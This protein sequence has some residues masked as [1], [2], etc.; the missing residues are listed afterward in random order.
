[1]AKNDFTQK[2]KVDPDE[3]VL[4]EVME[5]FKN[6]RD[7]YKKGYKDKWSNARKLY[8][9]QRV[10]VNYE[11][12]SDTFV[13][14]T[15]TIIQAV[16]SNVIGGK[17][18][19]DFLPTTDE[20]NGDT[21][22]LNA[23]NDQWWTQ[24]KTKLKASWAI[25][26]SLQVGN[27]YLWQYWNGEYP[28]NQYIPT[29]DNF[30]DPAATNYENLQWGGYRYLTTKKELEDEEIVN[31]QYNP[32]DDKSEL[33][34]KRY[35]NLDKVDE[36]TK[37]TYRGDKTAK[38]LREEMFSGST[39]NED[40]NLVE[41]IVFHDK[42]KIVRIANRC[43]VIENGDTWA[44]REASVI[45]SVDD[46]GQSVPVEIPEIE[47]FI[48]VAPARDYVDGALWYARGE[49][50][51][52]GDLQELLNDTQNQKSDNMALTNNMMAILDPSEAEKA[53]EIQ[54]APG[55]IFTL[56][57]GSI[58]FVKPNGIG[59]DADN[60]MARIQSM[61]GRATA[62]NELVQGASAQ[63]TQ[64]A[65]EINSR[66]MQTGTRFAS[67][68]E[69]YE[70]EFFATLANNM[71]KIGQI[72]MTQE[73]AVRMIGSEGVEWKSYNPGE[74][75]GNWD[76]KV[77]L[78]ANAKAIKEERKQE[79]MQFFLMA[80]KIPGVNVPQLARLTSGMLFDIDQ[81]ILDKVFPNEQMQAVQQLQMQKMAAETQQAQL[82]ALPQNNMP[83]GVAPQDAMPQQ[84][85][86]EMASAPQAQAENI[87][88]AA[89]QQGN[90]M[91]TPGMV[92][93]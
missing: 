61:M 53:D 83:Q 58:E 46:Q 22:V 75:L 13:P 73:Q 67:K 27:G 3:Q 51:V 12:S 18:K 15:F 91:N 88:S 17:V 24:D 49:I 33:M 64:S 23:L 40:K 76:V 63:G 87:A 56:P 38:Q 48:P 32:E 1:M 29:E 20:Q 81:N 16:K 43:T 57:P 59:Q 47:A 2:E 11:G 31:D 55:A 19:L 28:C 69:N 30:F 5:K 44:K 85:Q 89:V 37:K 35:K 25:E 36:Y 71:F 70:S 79:A 21:K 60:E 8:N 93:G 42:E 72:F 34:T 4:A 90:G 78:E 7:Y 86:G 6:A 74:Y 54:I 92:N 82:Q 66:L 68:L 45:Q 80:S 9:S 41:I 14:E 26:D 52:I 10:A 65:T 77:S 39:S 50:E 84:G 62:A